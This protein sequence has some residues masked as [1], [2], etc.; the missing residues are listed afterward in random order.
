[1]GGMVFSS[2]LFVF[3]FLP[4]VFLINLKL[5]CRVSNYFL[6]LVSL[7]AYAWG[8]PVY[9]LL[10]IA[11][12]LIN[13][14]LSLGFAKVRKR[15]LLMAVTVILNI[16]VLCI[17]KY[18][19][20]F[21]GTVNS[22][23]MT[24]IPLTGIPLPIGISFFTF[25][26]MSYSIDVYRG[27]NPPQKNFAKLLLYISLFPQLIAG[28]IVNYHDI[29]AS[30]DKRNVKL[31]E[32]VKGIRRFIMGLSKKLLIANVLA[33]IADQVYDVPL[34]G[35]NAPL[36]WMGALAYAA[37]IYFDFSGYSDMA[38]GMGHML[39]FTFLENFRYPYSSSSIRVFWQRWHISLSTWFR[40]YVYIHLGGN[41][42]GKWRTGL[43]RLLVFFLTGLWHGAEWTFVV[44]GLGHGLLLMLETYGILP[45][46]KLKAHFKWLGHLY[47]LTATVCLFVFFRSESFAQALDI[48]KS[49]FAGWHN[50]LAQQSLMAKLLTPHALIV[51]AARSARAL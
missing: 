40:E 43:N 42:K 11:C 45:V 9:V 36:A 23:F 4:V 49:M 18:A 30:L 50:T 6:L 7:V 25:Q 20:F 16:G 19:D 13:Y 32:A 15:K 1:M 8:E 27:V 2:V 17:Y 21:I 39:G 41:R 3:L 51:F 47:V 38:I 31:D 46:D 26:A 35:L 10:M 28:P 33:V 24:K 34:G 37:Q 5:P 22:L 44:W 48:L 14:L 12:T 29:E